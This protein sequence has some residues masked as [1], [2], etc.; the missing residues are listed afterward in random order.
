[1]FTRSTGWVLVIA[2]A[3]GLGLWAAQRWFA[4]SAPAIASLQSPDLKAI[5]L[6]AIRLYSQP[7][8][9]P[10][11]SLQQS[12]GTAFTPDELRGH[13]TVVFLGFTHCPDVCPTTLTDLAAAQKSW[14]TIPSHSRPRL[15]FVSVDPERD[16][17]ERIG[18]YTAYFHPDTLAA[19]APEP[20]LHEFATSLGMVYMK[21]PQGNGENYS[22]DHSSTLVVIDPQG[23][24]AG[25]IRQP[26]IPAEIARDLLVLT[27][28]LP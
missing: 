10:A 5:D 15:L 16:S 21:V 20:A 7:R 28:T 19:T 22:M 6:K 12:D 11:F 26:L 27:G 18:S 9:L 4:P 3:A 24:Q 17:P 13:W 8:A 23:R 2:L 14:Q 25:L 1:M